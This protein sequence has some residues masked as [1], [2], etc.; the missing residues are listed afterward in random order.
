MTT[1]AAGQQ[2]VDDLVGAG[3]EVG[4]QVAVLRDGELVVDAVGG[5]ADAHAG[6]PG[7]PGTLFYAASTAKGVAATVAHVLAERG[8]LDYDLRFVDVWPEFGA[9]GKE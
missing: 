9:P 6:R 5:L 1:Q 2:L 3:D 4:V 7:L 8:E